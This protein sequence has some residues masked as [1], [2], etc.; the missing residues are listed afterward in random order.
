MNIKTEFDYLNYV[1]NYFYYIFLTFGNSGK[2]NW[3]A[4]TAVLNVKLGGNGRDEWEEY[5]GF[6]VQWTHTMSYC[7]VI[8]D[9]NLL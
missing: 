7:M 4:S 3:E 8:C 5:R 9:Y 2:V 6:L 1:G